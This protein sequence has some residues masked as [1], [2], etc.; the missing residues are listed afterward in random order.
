MGSKHKH[1]H[2]NNKLFQAKP[3]PRSYESNFTIGQRSLKNSGIMFTVGSVDYFVDPYG[4]RYI[5]RPSRST[6]GRHSIDTRAIGRH[7]IDTRST[8]GI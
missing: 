6:L 7:L 4:D 8:L 2:I 1:K 3:D 5:G